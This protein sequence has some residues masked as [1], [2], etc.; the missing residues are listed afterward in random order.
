MVVR[1]MFSPNSQLPQYWSEGWSE[2]ASMDLVKM[3]FQKVDPWLWEKKFHQIL[4][5]LNIG[6][7]GLRLLLWTYSKWTFRKWIHGCEKKKSPNSQL[8]QY[9][10]EGSEIASMDLVKMDVQKVDP[11]L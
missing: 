2:I 9:W 5:S 1:K 6:P 10:S 7:R 4:N 3:D 8:P 11:W